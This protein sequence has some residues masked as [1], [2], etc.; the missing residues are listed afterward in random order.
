[1]KKK[2]PLSRS[3]I[4]SRIK[5][6]DTSIEIK[7]RKALWREGLRYR[8]N[9]KDVFGTPDICFK[10]DK[11]AVFCDSAFWHGKKYMEGERFKTNVEFWE[12]KIKKNMARDK[13]V[14]ETLKSEGWTVLRFWDEDIN[15]RLDE[16]VEVVKK[17]L[18]QK[19]N[20]EG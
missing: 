8:K 16:C 4:M 9:C 3:E 10:K 18:A 12:N 6:K 20:E 17:A 7:L 5:S 14:N 15:K 1:M 13:K 19:R 11:I 2:K